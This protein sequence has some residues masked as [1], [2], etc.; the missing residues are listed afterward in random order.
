VDFLRWE[1]V[2]FY[3]FFASFTG[4]GGSR[5]KGGMFFL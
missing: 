4:V 2:L 5:V 3:C 1:F